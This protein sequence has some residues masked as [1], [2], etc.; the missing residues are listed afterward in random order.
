MVSL[1]TELLQLKPISGE[2]PSSRENSLAPISVHK[3][4]VGVVVAHEDRDLEL[5]I[6]A[7][8]VEQVADQDRAGVD[9]QHLVHAVIGVVIQEFI[10]PFERVVV[11]LADAAKVAGDGRRAAQVDVR[12]VGAF[13]V[14]RFHIA[15]ADD[16]HGGGDGGQVAIRLPAPSSCGP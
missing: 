15:G 11:G 5:D 10:Q 9:V 16:L 6:H 2:V 8:A 3:P 14:Q 7:Q 12:A 4:G 13:G 1:L